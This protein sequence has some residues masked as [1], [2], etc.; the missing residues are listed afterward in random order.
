MQFNI[1]QNLG[2]PSKDRNNLFLRYHNN[3]DQCEYCYIKI[4]IGKSKP[5]YKYEFLFKMLPNKTYIVN[6]N[7][8]VLIGSDIRTFI[9][10]EK[11]VNQSSIIP[12]TENNIF[13]IQSDEVDEISTNSSGNNDISNIVNENQNMLF[14]EESNMNSTN[15]NENTENVENNQ[16]DFERLNIFN[17]PL[18]EYNWEDDTD[19]P[20]IQDT[21]FNDAFSNYKSDD[22]EF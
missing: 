3:E 19:I 18:T 7:C 12:L 10:P 15:A 16:L 13:Y 20:C 11:I 22:F 9:P 4:D 21:E 5:H 8:N 6:E 1:P 14:T 17:S 2:K